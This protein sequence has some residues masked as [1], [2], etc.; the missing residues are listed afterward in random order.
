MPWKGN[1]C[2]IRASYWRGKTQSTQKKVEL[3]NTSL[4]LALNVEMID[5]LMRLALLK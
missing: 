4:Q 2:K 5:F 1:V 3:E